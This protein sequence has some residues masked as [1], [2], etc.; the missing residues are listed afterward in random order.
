MQDLRDHVTGAFTDILTP[1]R[2]SGR[3]LIHGQLQWKTKQPWREY[4]QSG[5]YLHKDDYLHLLFPASP[6][7][8]LS[9]ISALSPLL[10]LPVSLTITSH[11]SLPLTRR[12]RQIINVKYIY[13]LSHK[14]LPN[15]ISRSNRPSRLTVITHSNTL[16]VGS[17]DLGLEESELGCV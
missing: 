16:C 15:G 3:A 8:P 9:R 11:T 4:N 2:V 1:P 6:S 17:G 7:F 12:S 14:G 5:C 10:L 13:A